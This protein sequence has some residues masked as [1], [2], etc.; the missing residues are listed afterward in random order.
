MNITPKFRAFKSNDGLWGVYE[1][2]AVQSY[3]DPYEFTY[4]LY[5]AVKF[6]SEQIAQ[7]IAAHLN[8]M[9]S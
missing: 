9:V 7:D 6:K 2:D 5:S 4:S 3:A 1:L 8:Y